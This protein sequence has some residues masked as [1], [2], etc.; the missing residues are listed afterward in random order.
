M[1]HLFFALAASALLLAGCSDNPFS[2]L[3]EADHQRGHVLDHTYPNSYRGIIPVS[4]SGNPG[5]PVLF[6]EA[7]DEDFFAA[8]FDVGSF[9]HTFPISGI[10][11]IS[12]GVYLQWTAPGSIF[13]K[14]VTVK[15]GPNYH[16]YNYGV[17]YASDHW[18]VSPL[19]DGG[20]IPQISNVVI[21]YT[22]GD[23]ENFG[24]TI[25][26]WQ[27]RALTTGDWLDTPY[28][29][30]PALNTVFGIPGSPAGVAALGNATMLEALSF[31]GGTGVLGGARILLRAA[32][33]AVLNASHP[34]VAYAIPNHNDVIA[35]VNLALTKGALTDAQ[36][37]AQMIA[38][39]D[40][41]DG[42]NNGGCPL[43]EMRSFIASE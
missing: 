27:N 23:P 29:A 5:N 6:C 9:P 14:V 22:G 19:N 30:N 11:L 42:Y 36:W 8:K 38:L 37:R 17:Q 7:I 31:G 24:C 28:A 20:N 40:L 10:Q 34:G 3:G 1:K 16:Q 13:V 21:C 2:P 41:L 33:A 26:F 32:A 43:G 39:A 25:G 35:A 18:L 4:H 12:D 15:G